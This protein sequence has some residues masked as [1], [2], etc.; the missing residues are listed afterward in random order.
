MPPDRRR[1]FAAFAQDHALTFQGAFALYE[2]GQLEEDTY[3]AYLDWFAANLSTPGGRTWWETWGRPFY[4]RRMVEA[5]DARLSRNDLPDIL[6]LP[7][8]QFDDSPTAA[9]EAKAGS[10]E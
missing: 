9:Q 7:D 4:V 5:V 10:K 6:A 8:F 3:R 1:V 2:S